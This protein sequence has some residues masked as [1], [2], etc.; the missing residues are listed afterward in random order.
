MIPYKIIDK[1]FDL[2]S[3]IRKKGL[4]KIELKKIIKGTK[5]I[6]PLAARTSASTMFPSIFA[7]AKSTIDKLFRLAIADETP[8]KLYPIN[9][10]SKKTIKVSMVEFKRILTD[11]DSPEKPDVKI[12][13]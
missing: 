10:L 6:I 12:L 7:E 9:G 5:P 8:P 11:A 1:S 13:K 4:I 3:L 2:F